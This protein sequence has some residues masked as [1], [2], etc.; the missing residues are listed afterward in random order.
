MGDSSYNELDEVQGISEEDQ[1]EILLEIEKVAGENR[2]VVSEG[3]FDFKPR[4][5]G[6]IFPLLVN[7]AGVIMLA[8]GIASLLWLFRAGEQQLLEEGRAVVT[9]ESRLIEEIRR[10]TEA[11]LA[12][13][14]DEITAIQTRLQ[15]IDAERTALAGNLEARVAQRE[16][17]LRRELEVE[18][19]AERR[20]L[21]QLN[22]SEEEIETRLASF[23]E[24][25]EREFAQRLDQFVRQ[26]EAE[27]ERL[28]Q[29]LN[30]REA[31]FN[32]SLAQAS[33]ERETLLQESSARLA[34]LQEEYEAELAAGIAQL[35]QAQAE[36]TRL[37][38]E[39]ERELLLRGQIR[40][41]YQT[42]AGAL[43]QGNYDVARSRLRDLRNLLN[44][45]SVLRIPALREQRPVDLL[46]IESLESLIRF[47]EQF[48]T[49]EAERT[50]SQGALVSRVQ[51][52]VDRAADSAQAGDMDQ[53]VAF[54]RQALD[55][56]PAIS[57]SYAF[58]GDLDDE[59]AAAELTAL[60]E[61]AARL[62]AEAEQ[63]YA[64]GSFSVAMSRYSTV[65]REYPRSR[66]RLDA[67]A[68]M[69]DTLATVQ[70]R[71][72]TLQNSLT[73]TVAELETDRT[74]LTE[75][76]DRT[77]ESLA[78]AE[79]EV[80][81][82]A[83]ESRE[84]QQRIVTLQAQTPVASAQIASLQQELGRTETRLADAQGR[85]ERLEQTV[86]ARDAALQSTEEELLNALNELAIA[87]ARTGTAADP[88][89]IAELERLQSLEEEL[90][91][92]RDQ[93]EVYR[94]E[95]ESID[96][97]AADIQILSARVSL[98]R[99]LNDA[100]MRRY[101]PDLAGE[102]ERFDAALV[103]GGRE[104]ALLDAA[105]LLMELADAESPAERTALIRQ[106]QAGA[107]PA[108]LDFLLELEP[109]VAAQ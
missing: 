67:A 69:E 14:D 5:N 82:R 52:L 37:G 40:G 74:T 73:E 58:I 71:N 80:A 26:A 45:E 93:W 39:Q 61:E 9:A 27:Q 29:E 88:Q 106:A 23:A 108:Y 18:L 13:K 16:S 66:Y 89:L 7:V 28:T 109:L 81:Q 95:A 104:N 72:L 42:A 6:A 57:E 19:E 50:L 11:Q 2:I 36:L 53:A 1:Q 105:D 102:I 24:V 101:F 99:F 77:R 98:E 83:S 44:E 55:V 46:L 43:R 15:E 59:S 34:A 21:Q 48:G 54:Y 41:L 20:R 90:L 33:R 78:E 97:T 51:D 22:L 60:N 30:Q 25:K 96:A 56:I 10:E 12:A 32:E 84:L 47:D 107:T 31:A 38:R 65:V 64:A 79:A 75:E 49:D 103:A 86:A 63:A 4:K 68:G 17:E 85:V 100:L 91:A 3:L 70:S 62:I 35:D 94:R 87:R 92:A 8:G 76:L